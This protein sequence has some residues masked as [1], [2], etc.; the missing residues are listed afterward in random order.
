MISDLDRAAI[1]AVK[2]GALDRAISLYSHA[3]AAGYMSRPTLAAAFNNRGA[4]YVRKGDRNLAAADYNEAIRLDP[5]LDEAFFNRGLLHEA[6]VEQQLA[7]RDFSQAFT[8]D[9][10][11]GE[12][13]AKLVEYGM[14]LR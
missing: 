12:Y 14:L 6:N 10:T 13:R 3:I 1:D 7:M 5:A 9:P 8:L 2:M 11:D 4:V